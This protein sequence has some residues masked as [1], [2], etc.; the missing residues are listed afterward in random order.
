MSIPE[1]KIKTSGRS[2]NK[3]GALRRAGGVA[4]P[5]RPLGIAK[6]LL[7]VAGMLLVG[8]AGLELVTADRQIKDALSKQLAKTPNSQRLSIESRARM[9]ELG[10]HVVYAYV[11]SH[12]LAGI[13]AVAAGLRL[14][15][16]PK[17]YAG[18]VLLFYALVVA[19]WTY[20]GPQM[21]IAGAIFR[22]PALLLIVVAYAQA[23]EAAKRFAMQ[24]T[25]ASHAPPPP[26]PE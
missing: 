6:A 11:V 24:A 16:S 18:S 17:E 3:V 19:G 13:A 10:F 9:E 5:E 7:V 26:L 22:G 21:L 4:S 15:N 12:I 14:Q 8:Y 23:R 1:I 20:L 25:L 2:R